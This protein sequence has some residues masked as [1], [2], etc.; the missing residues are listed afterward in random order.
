MAGSMEQLLL[1]DA[2]SETSR[3]LLTDWLVNSTTGLHRIR[4]GLPAGWKA[5]D[6]TGAGANGAINDIA[7]IWPPGRQPILMTVYMSES[8]QSTEDL[9]AAHAEIAGTVASYLVG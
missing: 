7:I 4:A 9:S 2:L 1:R 8:K 3:K 6:K 5:G